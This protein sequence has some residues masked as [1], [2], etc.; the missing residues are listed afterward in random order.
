M[1]KKERLKQFGFFTDNENKKHQSR[2]EEFA[3]KPFEELYREAIQL[4]QKGV[5]GNGKCAIKAVEILE[6]LRQKSRGNI[7]LEAYCGA[8][9]VLMG[10]YERNPMQKGIWIKKGL[11]II[12]R[13]QN[14]EPHNPQIRI[15]RGYSC[16]HL[17]VYF[18]RMGT[19]IE[20]FEYLLSRNQKEPGV[21]SEQMFRKITADLDSANKTKRRML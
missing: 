9:N 1:S 3:G 7:L 8:S 12:D 4:Y 2:T 20:D 13:A 6:Y 10:K 15:L 16:Y 18:K 19:A 5:S 21:I 11:D 14:K 17:P